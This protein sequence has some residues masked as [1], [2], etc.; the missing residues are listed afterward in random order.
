MQLKVTGLYHFEVVV[1]N[2]NDFDEEPYVSYFMF[3]E[4]EV[5]LTGKLIV[6]SFVMMLFILFV[7]YPFKIFI[8]DFGVSLISGELMSES[9]MT[10]L[11]SFQGENDGQPTN[12]GYHF[13]QDLMHDEKMLRDI[14]Q[15]DYDT[16]KRNSLHNDYHDGSRRR[17]TTQR[18]AG[19]M[20][21][22]GGKNR[23]ST[24]RN[25]RRTTRSSV[26]RG[27]SVF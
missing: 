12:D 7:Y 17:T 18:G 25:S 21:G 26:F 23:R 16:T 9:E 20:F 11:A 2:K 15:N 8:D 19:S 1:F 22:G 4:D 13:N 10:S 3:N 24:V 6:Q 14:I 5:D 27:M